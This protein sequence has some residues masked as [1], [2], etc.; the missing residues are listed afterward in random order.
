MTGFKP[1]QHTSILSESGLPKFTQ[2]LPM[3]LQHV[4]AA[5]VG[6]VT[7]AIMVAKVCRLSPQQQILLIQASLL[8]SAVST[9]L[10]CLPSFCRFGSRLPIFFGTSFAYV[11]TLL[12]LGGEFGISVLFG[13][14]AVGA[15]VAV[16]FGLFFKWLKP[17]FPPVV[18][19]TVVLAIGL[20]LYPTAISYMA[21]GK[22]SADFGSWQ[23]WLVAIITLAIVLAFQFFSKGALKLSALLMGIIGGYF[24]SACFGMI[25][26]SGLGEAQ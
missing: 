25:D 13:A 24:V 16:L 9:L 18:A 2:T 1:V 10:Q 12:A 5:I 17:L 19:G 11:P 22:S 3:A 23:N 26:M 8:M 7:P 15:V 6:I 21:G 20:S 14:Q 4:L